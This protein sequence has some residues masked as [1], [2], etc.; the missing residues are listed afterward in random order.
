MD[1]PTLEKLDT[2]SKQL[3]DFAL[4]FTEIII[5]LQ[6]KVDYSVIQQLLKAKCEVLSSAKKIEYEIEMKS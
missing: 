1:K 3:I 4:K 5:D 6:N 2:Y